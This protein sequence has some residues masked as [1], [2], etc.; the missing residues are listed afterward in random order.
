VPFHLPF[1]LGDLGERLNAARCEIVDPGTR[2]GHGEENSVPGLLFEGGLGLGW[3]HNTLDGSER[4]R[5]GDN[6]SKLGRTARVSL[7]VQIIFLATG[8]ERNMP[9]LFDLWRLSSTPVW[10][11]PPSFHIPNV[12]KGLPPIPL[13]GSGTLDSW[14]LAQLE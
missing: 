7:H 5:A 10:S 8:R 1:T 3:T 2:L 13:A 6:F 14:F 12:P 9:S 4:W 11:L